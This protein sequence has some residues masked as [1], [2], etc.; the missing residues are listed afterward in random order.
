M[1]AEAIE[2]AIR[3]KEE[4]AAEDDY[5]NRILQAAY[6]PGS[7]TKQ[8]A[9]TRLSRKQCRRSSKAVMHIQWK[10]QD[11]F[12]RRI[13]D[14]N[15]PCLCSWERLELDETKQRLALAAHPYQLQCPGF[16]MVCAGC[17][18]RA[19]LGDA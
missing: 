17:G 1:Y 3:V 16:I 12:L 9:A 13:L 8:A 18:A 2:D 4:A 11:D 6:L 15:F 19:R 14:E 10:Q 7:V 5:L